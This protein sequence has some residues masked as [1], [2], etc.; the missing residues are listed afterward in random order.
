ML[1][2]R[3]PQSLAEHNAN[4]IFDKQWPTPIAGERQFMHLPRFVEMTNL[5]SVRLTRVIGEVHPGI[6]PR[7]ALLGKP[8]VAP[9]GRTWIILPDR[10]STIH[11]EQTARCLHSPRVWPLCLA[12]RVH[13]RRK[14][15]VFRYGEELAMETRGVTAC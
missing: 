13:A 1:L 11:G 4:P 5:L 15:Y 12:A 14:T 9:G 6:A 3:P 2:N 10:G 8:A 7:K